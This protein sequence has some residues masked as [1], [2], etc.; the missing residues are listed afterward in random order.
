MKTLFGPLAPPTSGKALHCASV[1]STT[2]FERLICV[3]MVFDI[4][5]FSTPMSLHANATA[6]H[7]GRELSEAV[8]QL[9]MAGVLVSSVL[10]PGT[11]TPAGHGSCTTMLL[12][13]PK[14]LRTF[15]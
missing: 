1:V 10:P 6:L 4:G 12:M 5:G 3:T 9:P 14:V 11:I 15:V 8:P 13:K 2:G 7:S